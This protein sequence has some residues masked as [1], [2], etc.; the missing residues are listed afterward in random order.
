[1]A[2]QCWSETSSSPF[3]LFWLNIQYDTWVRIELISTM[4]EMSVYGDGPPNVTCWPSSRNNGGIYV[5]GSQ[6]VVRV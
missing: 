1:M 2:G 6:V 4:I 3:S 5:L